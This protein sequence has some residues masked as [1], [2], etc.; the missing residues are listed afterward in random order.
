[1]L[2]EELAVVGSMVQDQICEAQQTKIIF[3][4]SRHASNILFAIGKIVPVKG[5]LVVDTVWRVGATT[6]HERGKM[7][8]VVIPLANSAKMTV[9]L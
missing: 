8:H 6:L 7:D 9:P 1:M 3:H 2:L 4:L 5:E